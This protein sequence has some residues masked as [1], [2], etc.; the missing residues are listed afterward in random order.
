[1]HVYSTWNSPVQ[2]TG[3]GSLSLLQGNLPEPEIKPRS[4]AY[5]ADYLPAEPPGKPKK[6]GA[7]S[8]SLL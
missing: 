5:Q 7:G 4:P 1:M 6:T 2:N 3:V 8:L